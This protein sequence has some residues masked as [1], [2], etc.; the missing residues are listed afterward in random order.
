MMS[1]QQKLE[2]IL[3]DNPDLVVRG[4]PVCEQLIA[5]AEEYLEAEFP[6]E[7]REY[8][9]KYGW[10]AV[11]PMEFYGLT[12]DSPMLE[13]I[14]NGTWFTKQKRAQVGLPNDLFILLNNE[15]DE[16]HCVHLGAGEVVVWSTITKEV[17]AKKA[18][19]VFSYLY[20]EIEGFI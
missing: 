13:Q 17:I 20:E 14:P 11:G 12:I 8:F 5:E 3:L 4:A 2:K 10:I 6:S 19:S 18:D 9:L 1:S 16:F 7:L 15:G